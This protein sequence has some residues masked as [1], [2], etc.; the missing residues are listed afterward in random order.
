MDTLMT[1]SLI[2]AVAALAI[3]SFHIYLYCKE[4]KRRLDFDKEQMDIL[5][6]RIWA[7]EN[8]PKYKIGQ[9]IK[10]QKY[11][12]YRGQPCLITGVV[13]DVKIISHGTIHGWEYSIFDKGRTTKHSL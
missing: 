1:L 10:T 9:T 12:Q 2:I 13:A 5:E 7:L 3:F 4:L 6:E 8:P 11:Y